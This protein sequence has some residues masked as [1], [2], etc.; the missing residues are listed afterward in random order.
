MPWVP[1]LFSA[2]ALER[3]GE[4]HRRDHP[5]PIPYF[6]GLETG[7]VDAMVN[8]FGGVPELHHPVRGRIKGELE[9]RPAHPGWRQGFAAA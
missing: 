1:E 9:W 5:G 8:S 2:P 6:T 3:L 4:R 7:D